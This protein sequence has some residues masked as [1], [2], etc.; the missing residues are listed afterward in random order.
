MTSRD[1]LDTVRA[2]TK[3]V[4]NR[5]A[6]AWNAQRPLSLH[7]RPCLE[8]FAAKLPR[9]GHVL[10]LGCGSGAPIGGWFLEQGYRLTGLDYAPAMIEL[11][12]SQYKEGEWLVGDMRDLNLCGRYD[13][14][15]S[16][17][18]F[19]H[20]SREEQRAFFATLAPLMV[21]GAPLL[22]TVGPEDGEVTG[23]VAS[24]QVYHASLSPDEYRARLDA[25]GF[26]D[27]RIT[28][29]GEETAGRTLLTAVRT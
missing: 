28:P 15:I 25:A 7:E 16:W 5:Q 19:F 2:E 21:P 18:G 24:E 20:L 1:D 22:L 9:G 14:V 3:A 11:A 13:G 12:K 27:V 17:D 26:S 10:D 8:E 29:H 23:T 6:A 4:Y